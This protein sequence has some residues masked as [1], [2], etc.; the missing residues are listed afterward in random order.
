MG[1]PTRSGGSREE[2][3]GTGDR[4]DRLGATRRETR[5][6]SQTSCLGGSEKI[7]HRVGVGS[8]AGLWEVAGQKRFLVP[9][10]PKG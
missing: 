2:L 4:R 7:Q 9:K 8:W 10:T 5:D 1:D 6:G 3:R